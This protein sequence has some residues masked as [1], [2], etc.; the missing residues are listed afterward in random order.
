[1]GDKNI[2]DNITKYYES[3][4]YYNRYFKDI[5]F[6][7]IFITFVIGLVIYFYIKIRIE[8]IR[9]EWPSQRCNPIYIPFA[10]IIHKMDGKTTL[11]SGQINFMYCQSNILN[12]ITDKFFSPVDYLLSI[13][14][15]IFQMLI[16]AINNIRNIVQY[17]RQRI[18]EIIKPL[19]LKIMDILN[20]LIVILIY[21]KDIFAKGVGLLKTILF[22]IIGY[23]FTVASVIL[24]FYKIV[25]LMML[26]SLAATIAL[27]IIAYAMWW[28]PFI[29]IP[30][31]AGAILATLTTLVLITFTII[32]SI[33]TA[34]LFKKT[35]NT[36]PA[37]P[38]PDIEADKKKME[39]E[40]RAAEA[41]KAASGR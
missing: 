17:I 6:V 26:A 5:W 7:I 1:M 22:S 35:N 36:N 16:S 15:N 37:P 29:G 38:L 23:I 10:G 32:L 39:E 12:T 31:L 11:E 2:F 34:R 33:L 25:R 41:K 21:I 4:S 24:N 19:I 30:A 27:Y 14:N 18:L 9:K 8:A 20:P 13:I 40:K 3:L 28:F